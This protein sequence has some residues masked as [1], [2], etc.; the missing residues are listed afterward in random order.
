[1]IGSRLLRRRSAAIASAS[2]MPVHLG[3]PLIEDGDVERLAVADPSPAPRAA[4]PSRAPPCP[5]ARSGRATMRRFVAL[6]STTRTRRPVELDGTGSAC[7]RSPGRR[8]ASADEMEGAALARRRPRSRRSAS[9]PS[10]SASRRLM[11][12]PRPVPPK[13]REI[14]ASA[15]LNLW[16]SRPIRSAGCRCRCRGRRP[17]IS[18]GRSSPRPAGR[19][20]RRTASAP[21]RRA[22]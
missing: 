10:R 21:P 4:T 15:W 20:V 16:N 11:A 5:S 8:A 22:R 2:S 18:S 17:A 13:R 14:E 19:P 7:D 3:H 1:M 9:R 12:R 6:S